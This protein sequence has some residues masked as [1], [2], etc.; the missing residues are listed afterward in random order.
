MDQAEKLRNEV[1]LY[2]KM[3]SRVIAITSGKGGVGKSNTA[4]NLALCLK[5]LGK[6]VIIFDA[7]F[8]LANVEVMFKITP[9]YTLLDT[10]KGGVPIK[11]IIT[12]G[13][14]DIGFISGGS[15]IVS[16]NDLTTS[17]LDFIV[18]ELKTLGELCDILIVDTGAGV[19]KSVL[20]FVLASP[21]VLLITT[22]EP[23]SITDAYSLVKTL[24]NNKDY[25]K[26]TNKI[27]VITNKV[28]SKSEAEHIFNKISQVTKRFLD[29]ELLFAGMVYNDK[30]LNRAV[31]KQKVVSIDY[32]QSKA[33]KCFMDI[34]R[35]ITD[36]AED[37]SGLSRFLRFFI[38]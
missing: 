21:E 7:D 25:I 4:V 13:P 20:K 10:I 17:K 23:S 19:S 9:K 29:I 37:S 6:R 24:V 36:E 26:N 38:N 33:S 18:K 1:K 8:G 11:D 2:K 16:L 22:P 31:K 27:S 35:Y 14:M 15:G 30:N 5:K 34:A 32:P 3:E 12:N 28:S